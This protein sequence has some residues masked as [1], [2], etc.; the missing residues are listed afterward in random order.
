MSLKWKKDAPYKRLYSRDGEVFIEGKKPFLISAD[1]HFFGNKELVN[2][3]DMLLSAL[4]SCHMLSFLHVCHSQNI[5]VLEYEDNPSGELTLNNDGGGEFVKVSLYPK[6]KLDKQMN[7][8]SFEML[9]N[10]AKS[11]CFIAR[12]CNFPIL[13]FPTLKE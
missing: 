5:E 1:S 9:H 8:E 4:A 3:E 12:S 2:P 11:L 7:K 13:N 6:V 10:K